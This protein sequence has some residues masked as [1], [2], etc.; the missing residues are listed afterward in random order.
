VLRLCGSAARSSARALHELLSVGTA[1][2]EVFE[3]C[4]GFCRVLA[5]K[6]CI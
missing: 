5:V 4:G 3:L 2:D 1:K 6:M